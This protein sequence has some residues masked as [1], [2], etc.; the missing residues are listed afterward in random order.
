MRSSRTIL[1][2]TLVF[3]FIAPR[4][5]GQD[6]SFQFLADSVFECNTA[7]YL[8]EGP[9]GFDNY[10]WSTGDATQNLVVTESGMYSFVATSQLCS[11]EDS[12]F[13]DLLNGHIE[14]ID[15]TI[16]I[17][18]SL[19]LSVSLLNSAS[20]NPDGFSFYGELEGH[21]Y[22]RAQQPGTWFQARDLST[23][24]GGHLVTI[25]SALENAFVH[26]A[27]PAQH[28]W[29]G[30]T[31]E[32]GETNWQ[33]ITGEHVVYTNW[34]VGEPNNQNIEHYG[35][36]QVDAGWNDLNG[37]A[38]Y[39]F[40]LEFDN[41]ANVDI[42][43]S[44]GD[45]GTNIVV[46]PTETTT[47]Y[48]TFDN[49]LQSC[50]D[51]IVVSVESLE[52]SFQQDTLY[53]CGPLATLD[54]GIADSYAWSTGSTTQTIEV[55]EGSYS[56]EVSE[57]ACSAVDTIEVVILD[58][59]INEGNQQ[60]CLGESVTLTS[61]TSG[62]VLAGGNFPGFSFQGEFNGSNYYYSNGSSNLS[63]ARNNC[64]NIGGYL[65]SISSAAENN[66]VRNFLGGASAYIGFTD[67]VI[68]G[69]F[70]WM[71]GDP[72]TYTNWSAGEPNDLDFG[73]EDYTV[74][75]SSGLWNDV[76]GMASTRFVCEVSITN[77][78]SL[79]WSTG[80]TS[81]S[82]SVQP[83]EATWYSLTLSDNFQTC[84][85]SVLV[86]VFVPSFSLP[87]DT[88]FV[89]GPEAILDA[90]PGLVSYAWSTGGNTQTI[91]VTESG[92]YTVT[93]DEG[94]CISSDTIEAVLL[95]ASIVEGDQ[96]ICLGESV[97]L[98][99]ATNGSVQAGGNFPGF[100]SQGEF[101]GSNYY[102]STGSASVSSAR[103]SCTNIGGYLVSINSAAENSFISSFTG[104]T[105]VL[106]GLTDEV[107]EGSFVWM[108]GDPV[109]Y[110]NWNPG[111]PN[112]AGNEDYT[113]KTSSGGWNDVSTS[114]SFRFVCEVSITNPVS[115]LWST[116]ATTNSI[117]VQPT[118]ATWYS[119]TLTDSFQT[120]TDSVLVEVFVPNYSLPQDSLFVCGA[121]AVLDAGPGMT[122]YTWSTGGNTQTITVT[123]SG[124]Y[125]VTVD[126]GACITSDSVELF[127][128][129]STIVEG[130]Q[131]IC[132][133][134]TVNLS[135]NPGF[136]SP[137]SIN[138]YNYGGEFQG[139]VYFIN[140]QPTSWT[141][142]NSACNG[143]GGHLVS[144]GSAQ[145]NSFLLSIYAPARQWIGFTDQAQEG[146][147]Q[148]ASGEPVAYTNWNAP[149]EPNNSG[150]VEHYAE[151][152]GA[153]GLWNDMPNAQITSPFVCEFSNP[154]TV[155]IEWSTGET[156]EE[157]TVS[158]TADAT[159]FVNVTDE[160]QTCTDTVRVNVFEPQFN[161]GLDSLL[162]CAGETVLDAGSGW[163]SVLWS[164]GASGQTLTVNASGDYSVT[165]DEGACITQD[166]LAV[167]LLDA[168][169]LEGDQEICAGESLTLTTAAEGV[170]PPNNFVN[171]AFAGEF[172]GNYYYRSTV[173]S[174]WASA[175]A[176][177][178]TNGGHLAAIASAA[179]NNYVRSLFPSS[180]Q[181]I[182]FTDENS[183]GVFAWVNS[184]PVTYTNWGPGEPNNSGGIEDYTH[185]TTSGTWND[186][187]GGAP[188]FYTCEFDN[189]LGLDILWS[190][191]DTTAAIAVTP[192]V[193]TTYFVTINNGIQICSDTVQV[194]VNIPQF[195]FESDTVQV[196]GSETVLTA[197]EGFN[198]YLWS[199]G[200]DSTSTTV[201]QSGQY[202]IEVNEG[203]C[204]TSDTLYLSLVDATIAQNDTT[205]CF[206]QELILNTV[207]STVNQNSQL[208]GYNYGGELNGSY[209]FISTG[210]SNYLT[211][212][213]NCIGLGGHLATIGS[214]AEQ[215][216]VASLSTGN[217]YIGL[218]DIASE[219]TF[220]W[221]TGEPVTYTNWASLEPSNSLGNEDYTH[222]RPDDFWN[223]V[224][225]AELYF[226]ACEFSG[227]GDLEIVWS[228]GDAQPEIAFA[229]ELTGF[230]GVSVSDGVTV[231]TDSIFVEVS[232]LPQPF[233]GGDTLFVCEDGSLVLDPQV[234]AELFTWSTG[235]TSTSIEVSTD[236][237][238]SVTVTDTLGCV[239]TDATYV[240][241]FVSP[242]I[243]VAD[244]I[245]CIGEQV[246]LEL[247]LNLELVTWPDNSTGAS[248]SIMPS[249]DTLIVY[250]VFDGIATCTDS[251]TVRVSDIALQIATTLPSC[252]DDLNGAFNVVP[253]SGI[254]PYSFDWNGFNPNQL[255]KG[256]YLLTV[257]DAI[258][259]A[260]DTVLQMAEPAPFFLFS[261]GLPPF[262]EGET[263]VIIPQATGGTMPYTFDAGGV[264][265]NAVVSGVY[266]IT[267]QDA[268]GCDA[269]QSVIVGDATEVC[270]CTYEV[271]CNYNALATSD[272]GTCVYPA[273][274][275]DCAGNAICPELGLE[276]CVYSDACNYDP[277][278]LSDNGSCIY[279]AVGYNCDGICVAD[280]N[281]NG[282]CDFDEVFGCTYEEGFNY[283]PNATLDNGNCEFSCP[284]DFNGDGIINSADL[285]SFLGTF[286]TFCP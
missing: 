245:I 67:E 29:I 63:N 163:N 120:C 126:E 15:T 123:E 113:V 285:L 255:G 135:V 220:E 88:V 253:S 37:T 280:F 162:V 115:L 44:T 105:E 236:G 237:D 87:Q 272:D 247:A 31:D 24:A 108:N 228:T 161:F 137:T 270:G 16:C 117:S 219:G 56:V 276:G 256:S 193:T 10:V 200:S 55:G 242:P 278:A 275:F 114:S 267:A 194:V 95:D 50:T 223:D 157:I 49:G 131:D 94:A 23:S 122:S 99:S 282:I 187:S 146:N 151:I 76:S 147:W 69:S 39:P 68:E 230:Y 167:F 125:T 89:C 213:A 60:I 74:L 70:G 181:W 141:G 175:V 224:S 45:V 243:N 124:E 188:R 227:G 177:C 254:E 84:T 118:E 203:V 53:A 104:A 18:E 234:Q 207:N 145:E 52:F 41:P 121:E 58:P 30:F 204:T 252:Y 180:E 189:N 33:W 214:A 232:P 165:V 221:V 140:P 7:S 66:F 257:S 116:G 138:G 179:E 72:V 226:N 240:H 274:G 266:V 148:W 112:N 210:V 38:I 12:V 195:A 25:T 191:G 215:N 212:E 268:N 208:A 59:S 258:G 241:F 36:M 2:A 192:D 284:G 129:N 90:G 155:S 9:T 222:I 4:L 183:E 260:V 92:E 80:A 107:A 17:G 46:S 250:T 159:F 28:Q 65:V 172:N 233:L 173:Q 229:A 198:S 130:D 35:E 176:S 62:S 96:Q 3:G 81:N 202:T 42:T 127:L 43:W 239:N 97:T 47:Y 216:L 279:P 160:V 248:F 21:L 139:S 225:G 103:N 79:L 263:G 111:E 150:G 133:G 13:V 153:T 20:F 196:C 269:S 262:C 98:T 6:C 283:D 244:T 277:S 164:T 205:L 85:D 134:E 186:V 93:V 19:H 182:G 169:I 166:T 273:A 231:C 264:D 75:L 184:Q 128:L 14:Q 51:S 109:T 259:C 171:L 27:F 8:L 238:Y 71:N 40:L 170:E 48:V 168:T 86:E 217:I 106:I 83:T 218:N 174:T 271:A 178:A 119:L 34:Q 26:G 246:N 197:A 77:P 1:F 22:F 61:A 185:L 286:G 136:Q 190:T 110:T 132:L 11:V 149:V 143:I 91:T 142:A 281:N 82:I 101:N 73:G 152:T 54:A 261:V 251:A 100:N 154:T 57:G 158:P 206:G 32:L 201:N 144:I 249:V 209:Y 64:S 78:V 156:A 102:Y 265:M 211:A 235:S 5:L 199:T